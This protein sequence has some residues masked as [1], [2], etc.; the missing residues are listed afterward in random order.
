MQLGNGPAT[1]DVVDLLV[2]QEPRVVRGAYHTAFGEAPGEGEERRASA[3]A[4][5]HP[6]GLR[7]LTQPGEVLGGRQL[8]VERVPEL[9][10]HTGPQLVLERSAA[11]D[12]A[13]DVGQGRIGRRHREHRTHLGQGERGVL[14]PDRIGRVDLNLAAVAVVEQQP[15]IRLPHL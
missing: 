8:L 14:R 9:A 15:P 12:G 3:A 13:S 6:C 5:Q 11:V 7:Q 10:R 2:A 4:G 1:D